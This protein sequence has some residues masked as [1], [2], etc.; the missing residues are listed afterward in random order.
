MLESNKKCFNGLIGSWCNDNFSISMEFDHFSNNSE[1]HAFIEWTLAKP[2]GRRKKNF[3]RPMRLIA[4]EYSTQWEISM[5]C[6]IWWNH[7][8]FTVLNNWNFKLW[9]ILLIMEN[10]FSFIN[11]DF[12]RLLKIMDYESWTWWV[13]RWICILYY[14]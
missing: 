10:V 6:W 4:N 12:D 1:L 2:S 13:F 14:F 5:F 7:I 8:F 11:N 3:L 9:I